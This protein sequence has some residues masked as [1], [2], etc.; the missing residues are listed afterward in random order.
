MLI[1]VRSKKAKQVFLKAQ[2]YAKSQHVYDSGLETISN[3]VLANMYFELGEFDRARKLLDLCFINIETR[4]SWFDIY[5]NTY[6]TAIFLSFNDKNYN[7]SIKLI[8]AAERVASER[9]ITKLKQLADIWK[10]KYLLLIGKESEVISHI[11]HVQNLYIVNEDE[12]VE[13]WFAIKEYHSVLCEYYLANNLS[14]KC[15]FHANALF[16]ISERLGLEMEL[17]RAQIYYSLI[18]FSQGNQ[19]KCGKHTLIHQ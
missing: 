1:R 9:N 10:I 18:Y 6:R 15:I 14:Q 11:K 12:K 2:V 13:N 3:C 16:D 4:D 5:A 8:I 17:A 7:K 19:R